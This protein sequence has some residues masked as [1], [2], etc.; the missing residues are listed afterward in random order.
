[1]SVIMPP[2]P[3]GRCSEIVG[4]F[5]IVKLAEGIH[6][7]VLQEVEEPEPEDDVA[8]EEVADVGQE[9]EG[10][11]VEEQESDIAPDQEN[12]NAQ[13][14]ENSIARD[15]E[16]GIA[17]DQENSIAQDR[18]KGIAQDREKGIAQDREKGIAQNQDD[19]IGEVS[20]P[21]ESLPKKA[22]RKS[23]RGGRAKAAK[24]KRKLQ[25]EI[26]EKAN[27]DKD[28][29]TASKPASEADTVT[30]EPLLLPCRPPQPAEPIP[31]VYVDVVPA[32]E[33]RA[34]SGRIEKY[35][36]FA[37]EPIEPGVRII[38]EPPVFCLPAPGD[39]LI[40]VWNAYSKVNLHLK[41]EIH[42]LNLADSSTHEALN[43][44]AQTIVAKLAIIRMV[45]EKP[46]AERTE[47]E[48][49][50]C[51]E[52]LWLLG[53]SSEMWRVAARWYA[54]RWSLT[55]LP[56]SQ[57]HELVPGTPI[58]GLFVET[59]RLCHSCVPN[60]YA[61]YNAPENRM[62]VHTT[63]PIAT[64]EELTVSTLPS[65][66]YY[67]AA[68]RAKELQ[69]KFGIQCDCEACNPLHHKFTAHESARL[70]AHTRS[71]QVNHF[72]TIIEVINSERVLADLCLTR[73]MA[74][75]DASP[76]LQQ[77]RDVEA[78][79]LALIKN[80]QATGSN[81]AEQIRWY[82]ALIDR[83]QPRL[84]DEL[85]DRGRLTYWCF[86]LRHAGE[87]E[88]L[89]LRCFGADSVEVWELKKRKERIAGFIEVCKDRQEEVERA[90]KNIERSRMRIGL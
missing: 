34:I 80:L 22:T 47:E 61:H 6:D 23:R 36:L 63:K 37:T 14:Q 42:T 71:I 79:T 62:T 21:S 25:A 68:E 60:C 76:S 78:T 7:A 5:E 26:E 53:K 49:T 11:I 40:E 32:Y 85:D 39:Q 86:M 29:D 38:S 4:V 3:T 44:I 16:K 46:A 17:Q 43:Y 84:A 27:N 72:T 18:E 52:V 56:D 73:E 41:K 10:D 90:R 15:Q 88:K 50:G 9:Q 69:R 65:T 33:F 55:N 81:G 48:V 30:T 74:P 75:A 24:A 82:N 2:R 57:R 35:G 83:I 31:Y 8:E 66:Y 59:A 51:L 13:D 89:G 87:C 58:T 70:A 45:G 54:G 67:S 64:D 19:G 28:D 77:L 20:K 12:D 1:M